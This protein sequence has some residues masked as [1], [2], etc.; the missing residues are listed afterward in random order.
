MVPQERDHRR[1]LRGGG[2]LQA[3]VDGIFVAFVFFQEEWC[4]VARR[5]RHHRLLLLGRAHTGGAEDLGAST[6]KAVGVGPHVFRLV[7]D[8]VSGSVLTEEL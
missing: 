8:G 5:L 1:H 2:F 7:G 4:L 3:I 6:L